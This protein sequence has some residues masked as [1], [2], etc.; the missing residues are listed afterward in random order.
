MPVWS[1][2]EGE[3]VAV[4]TGGVRDG[5]ALQRRVSQSGRWRLRVGWAGWSCGTGQNYKT[6][7]VFRFSEYVWQDK[8]CSGTASHWLYPT[9]CACHW[10][11][12]ASSQSLKFIFYITLFLFDLRQSSALTFRTFALEGFACGSSEVGGQ[13]RRPP[14]R[15]AAKGSCL[16]HGATA[17]PSLSRRPARLGTLCP[18]SHCRARWLPSGDECKAR[19]GNVTRRGLCETEARRVA[20]SK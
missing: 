16:C 12:E 19:E 1:R 5:V 11:K 10:P 17:A 8:P 9:L 3:G 13:G 7:A 18:L 6:I 14:A 20:R 15:F 2:R 4:K